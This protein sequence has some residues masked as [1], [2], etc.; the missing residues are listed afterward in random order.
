LKIHIILCLVLATI[1]HAVEIRVAT[2]NI[3]ANL[4]TTSSNQVYFDYGLGA[5]GTTDYESVKAILG[6]ID[7]DIITLQ[8]IHS[9]DISNNDL[10]DLAAS[11]GYLYVYDP[12]TSNAFDPSLRVVFLSRFPFLSTVAI[13]S[14]A[15]DKDMTRLI[16]AVRVDVPGT[17]RDP[18]IIG[19]H[20]KSGTGVPDRFQRAV[21]M[22]R[23]TD[24]LLANG[25]GDN[26]NFI[27]LGDFN[28]SGNDRNFSG[29]PSS[30]IPSSF[31]L[32][33][34][35]SF[36]VNY[37]TDAT[38][39]FSA[40]TV[41]Q[42]IAQQL[43][44]SIATFDSGS[45]LDL[46]L[47][48]SIIGSRPLRTE[49][50]NSALDLSN[51][52]GLSK[53]GAPLAPGTSAAASD[54]L[55]LF[56]DFEL[57]AAPP[58]QF[59]TAGQ[60]I[61]ETFANFSG[62]YD[63]YPWATTDGT[64]LGTDDG[65]ATA[66]GFRSYGSP[67]DPSL[68]LIT[69]AAGASAT[70][71][72][73]NQSNQNLQ[74]L[75]VSFTAEQWRS[76][77]AGTIDTLSAELLVSA[78]ST[79]VPALTV[80]I[81]NSAPSGPLVG[82]QS[83]PMSA[84]ILGLDIP[85]GQPFEL[86]FNF[87]QGSGGG[88]LPADVFI[89]EF[90]YDNTGDDADE[91]VEIVAGPGFTGNLSEAVLI[92]YNGNGGRPYGAAHPLSSFTQGPATDTGHR[93]F[94]KAISGIQ[95]GPD[96]FALV[97]NGAVTQFISYEGSITATEGAADGMTSTDIGFSQSSTD[98]AGL[99]SLGLT[100]T[101][102]NA[103]GFSWT[104]FNGLPFTAG[105]ANSEQTFTAPPQSQGVAIDDLAITFLTD[106][107]RDG[108]FDLDE[109]TLGT[110]PE[111]A[112]SFFKT[113]IHQSSANQVDLSFPTKTGRSYTLESSIDLKSWEEFATYPGSGNTVTEAL[114]I[115]PEIPNRFLRVRVSLNTP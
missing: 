106:S 3:G 115:V 43:D 26:D 9:V 83:T 60:T 110:D 114:T 32:G 55:A 100:E 23:L 27:V 98:A 95:N 89:N 62:T 22:Q 74:A 113:T 39:Y 88:P 102:G 18:L 47:V 94:S 63:P 36:P 87:A 70:A 93:I 48:S 59:T 33:D 103:D 75:R 14:P 90:H 50:Y 79:P 67:S 99:S 91:F 38:A 41:T 35:I 15:G 46:F 81:G 5:P 72:F 40:P 64:W 73:V 109:L 44:G 16:P 71:S 28:L 84:D 78:T 6:R 34:D 56:G 49:I 105:Q 45:T 53:A 52:D 101:A 19:T 11:L 20:L 76:A 30:G 82:G 8:E 10:A 80:E 13:R 57:D 92:L 2:F 4:N 85:P 25:V 58:Y 65:S 111:D 17:N 24:H 86:R 61:T 66:P 69:A 31:V 7:A 54:H 21:E 97:V 68:G 107:D 96:G 104:R 51:T 12:G 1:V 112:T 77:Q 29:I 42:I 108:F 37:Y